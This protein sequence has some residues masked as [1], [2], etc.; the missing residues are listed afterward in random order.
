MKTVLISLIYSLFSFFLQAQ[1]QY[2]GK[3]TCSESLVFSDLV[4]SLYFKD[5]LLIASEFVLDDGTFILEFGKCDSCFLV[6]DGGD[7]VPYK[8]SLMVV[9]STNL[10]T[11]E[12]QKIKQA[13]DE[14]VVQ[15]KKPF[16]ERKPGMVVVNAQESVLATGLSSFEFLEK[17]P[18]L[19]IDAN[20]NIFLNGKG[21][22]MV[23][24][25]GKNLPQ[26]G[27]ELANYLR[28]IP[29]SMIDKIELISN[30]SAKFDAAGAA[31][32][33]IIL[34]K[35][36]RLGTNGS[37]NIG[38]G[39]GYYPKFN[40]GANINHRTKKINVYASYNYS[41]RIGMNSLKLDRYFYDQGNLNGGYLQDNFLLMKIG[42]HNLK[43][44]LDWQLDSKNSLRFG[45]NGLFSQFLID[46]HNHSDVLDSLQQL[47]ST[48]E[49]FT[50]NDD[51]WGSLGASVAYQRNLDTL[52][53]EWTID[54]DYSKYGHNSLQ[55]I[56]SYYYLTNGQTYQNPYLLKGDLNG[57][58]DLFAAKTDLRKYFSKNV[59][60]EAGAKV[61]YV[62]A[63]NNLMFNDVS[64]GQP[65]Y[66]STKS[67]HYIYR[68]NINA[69]YVLFNRTYKNW[70]Y[71]LGLRGELSHIV[72]EQ[73][74]Y[75]T[76][77]D[78]LYFQL[79]PSLALK[80]GK[81]ENHQWDLTLS[82]RIDRPSY[83]QLNPFK[84]YLDPTTYKVGNPALGPQTTIGLEL[85]YMLKQRHVFTAAYGRTSNNITEIIAPVLGQS[86]LTAQT[87]INLANVDVMSLTSSLNFD[88]RPWWTSMLNISGYYAS[89]SGNAAQTQINK[90]G[91]FVVDLN[92]VNTF[93]LP[94]SWIIELS[95]MY[96]SPE[97]YAFDHIRSLWALNIGVQ[98]KI[99]N[100]RGVLKLSV[101]DIFYTSNISA[102]VHFTD[103]D[104]HFIVKRDVRVAML[105]FTYKFGKTTVA[106]AKRRG[107]ASDDLKGRI[108]VGG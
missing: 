32:I 97:K 67:N 2:S 18:G 45:V 49:T 85:S 103:Y 31:I 14:I 38:G 60:L 87:I 10:G 78:T 57:K 90:Q 92:A 74:V 73:R 16:L 46:G 53:S 77:R 65:V 89:Y 76:K 4:V 99:L 13:T 40:V 94:K 105:S 7:I 37:F 42:S 19:R 58:L 43:T 88:I 69:A 70:S 35:D 64:N 8:T 50:K 26:S 91:N 59:S 61:S 68:E 5:S 39:H 83:D 34:K 80:F 27:Q 101:N 22:V 25:N 106:G 1:E 11:F 75:Q 81:N 28:G 3:L 54:M 44:G 100:Y 41:R 6:F 15:S 107:S 79:F 33:N 55:D 12:I 23:Q 86:K 104:E 63:D 98:K 93:I 21:G 96:H 84:F 29:S 20:E 66:D 72:G 17:L 36:M 48:F 51:R 24:I 95:G 56:N 102:N 62:V 52:N 108:Q 71:Q 82:R 30:P 9:D 47:T